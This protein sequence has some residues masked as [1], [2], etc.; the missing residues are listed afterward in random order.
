M[1][2]KKNAVATGFIG[3]VG[4]IGDSAN[5]ATTG[6]IGVLGQLLRKAGSKSHGSRKMKSLMLALTGAAVGAASKAYTNKRIDAGFTRTGVN[7]NGTGSLVSLGGKRAVES[8]NYQTGV[9][10]AQDLTDFDTR[11][12]QKSY[13]PTYPKDKSGWIPGNANDL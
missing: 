3:R 1:T 12:A 9:T 5:Y 6:K 7:S 2:F 10:V 11:V 8:V 13:P 4:V